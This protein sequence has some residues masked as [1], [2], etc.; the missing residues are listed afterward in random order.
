MAGKWTPNLDKWH[1]SKISFP[2]PGQGQTL[3][4]EQRFKDVCLSSSG[5]RRGFWPQKPGRLMWSRIS[6]VSQFQNRG[7]VLQQ[8]CWPPK[9]PR[10]EENA[11]W[12][13]HLWQ[14]GPFIH[15]KRALRHHTGFA[16]QE[17]N[18]SRPTWPCTVLWGKL[19]SQRSGA[20]LM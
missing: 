12:E 18:T 6:N 8:H 1:P 7:W 14:R 4:P 15:V 9:S 3:H 20:E 13:R 5:P 17:S 11:R 16:I 10:P 19:S 2:T